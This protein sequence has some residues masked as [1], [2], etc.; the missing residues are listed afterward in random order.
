MS[1]GSRPSGCLPC[2]FPL[3]VVDD[4][5]GRIQAVVTVSAS[6]SVKQWCRAFG[7]PLCP[8]AS[9]VVVA[10][11]SANGVNGHFV[12]LNRRAP[13]ARTGAHGV[14]RLVPAAHR[15]LAL[16]ERDAE[17][18]TAL[19]VDEHQHPRALQSRRRV[20]EF[21]LAAGPS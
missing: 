14:K 4:H 18:L 17:A 12:E 19:A 10:G 11:S 2:P 5:D 15:F 3:S 21:D 13:F 16:E 8:L 20:A 1:P 7:P 9:M 6:S